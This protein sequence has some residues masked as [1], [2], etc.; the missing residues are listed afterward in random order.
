M[1][2]FKLKNILKLASMGTIAASLL[3]PLASGTPAEAAI[4]LRGIVEGFYGTLWGYGILPSSLT[5]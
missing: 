1:T 4:P 3:L 5:T 2:E